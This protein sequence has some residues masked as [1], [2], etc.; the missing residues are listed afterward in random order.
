MWLI[1]SIIGIITM[2]IVAMLVRRSKRKGRA[3]A[4][5]RLQQLFWS[6]EEAEKLLAR[7]EELGQDASANNHLYNSMRKGYQERIDQATEEIAGVKSTLRRELEDKQRIGQAYTVE[8]ERLAARL[9]TGELPLQKHES[10][11]RKLAKNAKQIEADIRTMERLISAESST[12]VRAS[13][14]ST[15]QRVRPPRIRTKKV[16]EVP[17]PLEGTAKVEGGRSLRLPRLMGI[18]G[19]VVLVVV[20]VAL[21]T[22]R[23]PP[24]T[25]HPWPMLG[26][27]AQWSFRSPYRGPEV[28]E[29]SWTVS[30]PDI[31]SPPL[32]GEGGCVYFSQ[33]QNGI[34]V[35]TALNPDGSTRKTVKVS[36]DSPFGEIGGL[37]LAPGPI[38]ASYGLYGAEDAMVLVALDAAMEEL[39][40]THLDVFVYPAWFSTLSPDGTLYLLGVQDLDDNEWPRTLT[41]I[42]DDGIQKWRLELPDMRSNVALDSRGTIHVYREDGRVHAYDSQGRQRWASDILAGNDEHCWLAVGPD[43]TVYTL[44][45]PIDSRQY[46]RVYGLVE[47]GY[48]K[49]QVDIPESAAD[50]RPPAVGPDGGLYIHFGD[51]TLYRIDRYGQLAVF[52][53][54]SGDFESLMLIDS[55][56]NIYVGADNILYAFNPDGSAKW[57]LPI[58]A[59]SLFH[60]MMGAD[61]TIYA[62]DPGWNAKLYTISCVK[63]DRGLERERV[64]FPD[65][66]LELAIRQAIDKPA[67]GIHKC[68][69]DGLTTLYAWDSNITDLNGLQHCTSL[70]RLSLKNNNISDISPLVDN[71]G[72]GRGGEVDLRDNPLSSDSIN[73]YLPQ[74]QNR[75]VTVYY[76]QYQK[77]KTYLEPPPMI[78]DTGNLYV[79]TIETA[80]GKLVLELFACDAPVT[81]NNF[82]FLARD[83]F[84][85]DLTFHRVIPGFMAQG[86]CPIG[87]GTG[88]PGYQF[89]DEITDHKHGTGALSMANSGPNTNGSQFFIT[90][91][92]Q[93]HLDGKHSVFGQLIEGMDVLESL[94]NGDRMLRVTIQEG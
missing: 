58:P 63:V 74:L 92:P 54:I 48:I 68:D 51:A 46:T 22:G 35:I 67:G 39:W 28:P 75:G 73:L 88:G 24:T 89:D 83:G 23:Q 25:T 85:D 1:Y 60:L 44:A 34:V 56:N 36:H 9:R 93:P 82:V 38:V 21:L 79:A 26:G 77:P 57:E 19:G 62:W 70:T 8:R 13:C 81:V 7:L 52:A 91:A 12:E 61:G 53:T 33:E 31:D 69:L 16:E 84:Y 17:F 64:A 76:A 4:A 6:K 11:E 71:P 15:A 86:G 30:L 47:P 42:Q 3:I 49:W 80:K 41:A 66:G 2:T 40:R 45:L 5:K 29:I 27:D 43:D 50:F 10:L 87:D 94:E 72:L 90:Y 78:V 65:P 18:V 37:L 20:V 55:A 14:D 32:L 59:E